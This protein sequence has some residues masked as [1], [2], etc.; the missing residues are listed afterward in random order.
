[1]IK[2]FPVSRLTRTYLYFSLWWPK[3][4]EQT[5]TPRAVTM[6]TCRG[7]RTDTMVCCK[8]NRFSKCILCACV[9]AGSKCSNCL[10]SRVGTC[11]NLQEDNSLERVSQPLQTMPT[12]TAQSPGQEQCPSQPQ[13]SP[14]T[15]R[16]QADN[17]EWP[18]PTL[19]EPNFM[20]GDLQGL[21][22]CHKAKEVYN[23]AVHWRRNLFQVPSGSAGKAFVAELTRLYQAYADGSCLESV[24]LTACSITP[25]LLLQKPSRTSKS[26]DH[27]IHLQRRLDLWHKGE[28]HAL[29]T[30][31]RCIQKH[32]GTGSRRMDDDVIAR[33]FRDVVL[34]GKVR[35]A[36]RFLSRNTSG[37]VLK[38]DE[39]IP[40]KAEEGETV[41]RS[42]REIL[43][44]K[45]PEA[46]A[47]TPSTLLDNVDTPEPANPILF[48][49]LS[50]ETILQSA[51]HTQGS[52]GPSSLDAQAWR[53]MCS[54]FKSASTDLC[55]ALANVGKHIATTPVHPDGLG[56]FVACRLIPI[57]KCPGVR[58]IGVGEVPR[59]I[60]A[61]AFLRI[62]KKDVEEA[63]GPL[64]LCAG[65][66]GGC[67][68]A[69]HA[70]KLIS[71]IRIQR[72]PYWWT[73]Q[74][75]STPS[76]GNLLFTTLMCCA[77]LLPKYL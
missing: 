70:M 18:L 57:D 29:L 39:L 9:K 53:R 68:A 36:L 40:D 49:E 74:T 64:Q 22:F 48:D 23:E 16:T 28:L 37:G 5:H 59:R 21:D 71:K 34:N 26:R 11:C 44:D 35:D 3:N 17:V 24:A 10:P 12:M 55:A 41:M 54:S 6:H 50:Q 30:E 1:M 67:E 61:K 47:P 15:S 76:I 45:H 56:A 62:L 20:W 31:A 51:L 60:I 77:P 52:A 43:E 75:P 7:V 27:T 73:Q 46:A 2:V 25:I 13:N 4:Y 63:A 8:C 65:Q 33:T 72:P 42:V 58:P 14:H 69:V 66:D 38:L 19:E 32:M